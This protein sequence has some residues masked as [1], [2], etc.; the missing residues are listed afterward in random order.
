MPCGRKGLCVVP[1]ESSLLAEICGHNLP[2]AESWLSS[3]DGCCREGH[4]NAGSRMGR[5]GWG[6][7]E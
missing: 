4:A 3:R 2:A 6:G 5:S 7:C 1:E